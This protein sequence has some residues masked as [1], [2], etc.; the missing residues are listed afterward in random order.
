MGVCIGKYVATTIR[1]IFPLYSHL[2]RLWQV[3]STRKCIY[4]SL[5]LEVF[6]GALWYDAPLPALQ[7]TDKVYTNSNELTL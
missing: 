6:N 2:P 5:D 3:D 7:E 1:N 4:P